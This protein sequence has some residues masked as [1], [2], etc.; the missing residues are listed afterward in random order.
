MGGPHVKGERASEAPSRSRDKTLFTI[1]A[2]FARALG[3]M[4]Q[5]HCHVASQGENR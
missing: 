1:Y 5:K 4:G 3:L 2:I